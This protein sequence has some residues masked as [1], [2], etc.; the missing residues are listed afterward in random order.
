MKKIRIKN[1]SMSDMKI[2]LVNGRNTGKILEPKEISSAAEAMEIGD[3][4]AKEVA[5][6]LKL[7]I[8]V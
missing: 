4:M 3:N 2:A 7:Q 1:N 8:S 6:K 5:K